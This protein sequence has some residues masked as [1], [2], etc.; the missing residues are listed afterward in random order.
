MKRIELAP[1]LSSCIETVAK[2]E[3]AETTKRLLAS[4][5]HDRELAEKAEVLRVF[6]ENADLRRLR[7]AS[8]EYLLAGR[9]VVFRLSL[10]DD[11]SKHEMKVI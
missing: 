5:K 9:R 6:L 2:R 1:N 4:E 3:Y 7:A 8:E 10:D 11:I